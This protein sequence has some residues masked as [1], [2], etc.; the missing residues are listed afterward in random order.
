MDETLQPA[1]LLA[2][3]PK[4]TEKARGCSPSDE[5]LGDLDV[6]VLSGERLFQSHQDQRLLL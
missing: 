5:P 2:L 1:P 3:L 4:I 6:H